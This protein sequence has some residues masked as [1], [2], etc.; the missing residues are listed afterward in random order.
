[1]I[2]SAEADYWPRLSGEFERAK[3]YWN[4]VRHVEPPVNRQI[5]PLPVLVA[6]K[7]GKPVQ[8]WVGLREVSQALSQITRGEYDD[9]ILASK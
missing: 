7:A 1:L 6:Y 4:M 3:G 9:F 5:G 8:N 2:A